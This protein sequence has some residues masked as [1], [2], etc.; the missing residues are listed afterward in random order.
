MPE[1]L[2]VS[3]MGSS[4]LPPPFR[5]LHSPGV[6]KH[7]QIIFACYFRK[8]SNQKWDDVTPSFIRADRQIEVRHSEFDDTSLTTKWILMILKIKPAAHGKGNNPAMRNWSEIKH[9]GAIYIVIGVHES[10]CPLE[11][12]LTDWLLWFNRGRDTER[13]CTTV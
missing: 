8:L 6:R 9:K 13:Y 12:Y 11:I 2:K 3:Q 5:G 7:C 4:P 10:H 1:D